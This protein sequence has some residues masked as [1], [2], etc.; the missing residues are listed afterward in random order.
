MLIPTSE[1]LERELHKAIEEATQDERELWFEHPLTVALA[2]FFEAVRMRTFEEFEAGVDSH[3][4][5]ALGGQARLC[6]DLAAFVREVRAQRE[7]DSAS[8]D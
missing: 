1:E 6:S 4:A 7:E 3:A 5:A 8:N 2:T